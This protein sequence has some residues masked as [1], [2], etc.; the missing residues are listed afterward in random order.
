M[1]RIHIWL[2]SLVSLCITSSCVNELDNYENPKGGIFGTIVDAETKEPIPLPVQGS[3][4]VIIKM[5]EQG[6]DAT[7][8]FDF[9]AKHDGTFEN[10]RIF[11]C[12]YLITADGPFTEPAKVQTTIHGR[13]EV[14]I[15]AIPYARIE[16]SAVV[17]GKI[18]TIQYRIK[19]TKDSYATS[20]VYGYWNFVPGVD[21]GGANQAGKV[22]VH[23][24]TGTITF[25]LSKDQVFLDNSYKIES[26]E[27]KIYIRVGAKTEGVINYSQV[28]VVT[29]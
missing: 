2:L 1:K 13:T 12:D 3:T 24:L 11:D 4:G 29:L 21:D 25:D 20:E 9:Y 7:K 10:S 17:S 23:E 5:M 26:D 18:V 27:N 28:V 8:S 22:T 15:P 14:T 6:T 19:K 16:A